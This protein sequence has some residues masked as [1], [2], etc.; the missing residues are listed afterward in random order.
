AAEHE[1]QVAVPA[2]IV[3]ERGDAPAGAQD[4]V[5]VPGVWVADLGRL[6]E[7]DADVAPVG[8]ATAEPLDP[9]VQAGVADRGRPHVDAA[10]ARAQVEP[11]TDHRDRRRRF[12]VWHFGKA[13]AVWTTVARQ[14]R[15]HLCLMN[16]MTTP[17]LAL[18]PLN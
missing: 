3:D 12:R 4:R 6:R 15:E 13:T 11:G 10:T 1:R 2:R 17:A 14:E 18:R 16:V 8:D 7:T 9:F 5:E